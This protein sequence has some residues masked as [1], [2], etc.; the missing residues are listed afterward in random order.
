MRIFY[1]VSQLKKEAKAQG[2][3]WAFIPTMG[4]LHDGH[5]SLIEQAKQQNLPTIV[6]V[7][8]NPTQFNNSEDLAK[9]PRTVSQ[10]LK[11]LAEIG[12][13]AV[14]LPGIQDIYPDNSSVPEVHLGSEAK[15]LE[16]FYRPGHFEGVVMVLRRLF[17]IVQPGHVFFGQ[18]DLQ[19]CM[20][21]RSLINNEFPE[22]RFN[23]VETMREKGGLAMSSRNVHISDSDRINANK[24]YQTLIKM[25]E[26]ELNESEVLDLENELLELGIQTEYLKYVSLPSL[27][28]VTTRAE[29]NAVVFAGYLGKVR[30]IDN[31]IFK[32]L[33][34]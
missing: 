7:F 33:S 3:H 13:D 22:I 23:M 32:P 16:G 12:V 9:Y 8:V 17:S 21:V 27:G 19:Q 29:A 2:G 5:L 26:L 11:K 18:K 14:F 1:S 25:S 31:L 28:V 6:S 15:N 20:V 24:I 34:N 30:L 10:D 4:A